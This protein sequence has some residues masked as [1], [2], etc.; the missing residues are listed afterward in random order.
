M[1]HPRVDLIA[2]FQATIP[3]LLLFLLIDAG[4]EKL[5]VSLTGTS[6]VATFEKMHGAPFGAGFH[7]VNLLLFFGEMY[8]VML[9]FGLVR[10]RFPL[11]IGAVMITSAFFLIFLGLFLG[12]MIN[13]GIYPKTTGAVFLLSSVVAFPPSV[14]LGAFVYDWRAR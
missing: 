5:A 12:Q 10:L 9:F 2:A 1:N 8:L 3:A 14:L 11:G 13:L 7:L 6:V 4:V